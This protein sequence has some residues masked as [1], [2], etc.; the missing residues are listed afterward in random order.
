MAGVVLGPSLI[1]VVAAPAHGPNGDPLLDLAQIGLC[2]LLFQ[3]GL[4]TKTEDARRR[5]S[6]WTISCP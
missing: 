6:G 4:E 5:V 3:V 1:G 2:V